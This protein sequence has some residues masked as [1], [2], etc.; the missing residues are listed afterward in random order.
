[1]KKLVILL[2]VLLWGLH[3][4][5]QQDTSAKLVKM[6]W[7]K[8]EHI[9]KQKWD[10]IGKLGALQD[11]MIVLF[12]NPQNAN[13]PHP[14][15]L[16]IVDIKKIEVR[17]KANLVG[18]VLLGAF[19]GG[20]ITVAMNKALNQR[21]TETSTEQLFR[22]GAVGGLIGMAVFKFREKPLWVINI[23]GKKDT[24]QANK[25]SLIPYVLK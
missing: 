8:I 15:N 20:G 17:G 7:V 23:N 16:N 18:R 25:A 24:Y 11:S 5:A 3:G 9:K 22:A 13:N 10:Q 6:P 21:S 19:I 14:V 4:N 12:K 1:M 2:P